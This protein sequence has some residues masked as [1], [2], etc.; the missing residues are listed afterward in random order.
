LLRTR[1]LTALIAIPVVAW[2]IWAGGWWLFTAV[3][4]VAVMAGYEFGR[5]MRHG[6]YAP[7]LILV[8]SAIGI[9]VLDAQFP[10]LDIA[11]PGLTWLLILSIT[12]QLF[13]SQDKVP[14]AS[15]ALTIAGGLYVGW[16][17]A[18]A[19]RLR[20]LPDGMA[21]TT[22]AV[23]VTWTGDTA[24]YFVGRGIG[25]HRLW[26]R[27]SPQKTWEGLLGGAL[28]SLLAG[29][30]VGILAMK[31]FGAIGPGQGIIVGILAAVVGPLGDLAISMMK[32][33][34]N[35][36]DSS[37]IIPGHGGFLDRI[38]SL[39]LIVTTTYYYVLWFAG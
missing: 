21:W 2:V 11:R 22:L 12:W 29:G 6:G 35:V 33:Q 8:L 28:V 1:V 27:L 30:A 3:L 25:R 5:L 18:H 19:I 13:R 10:S 16:L 38:D 34:V 14:T 15:W 26:P 20:A 23:I 39:L 4:V 9:S 31:W 7:A 37:H 32:R 24:A 17:C 36:K